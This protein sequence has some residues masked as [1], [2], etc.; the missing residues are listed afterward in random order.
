V[1]ALAAYSHSAS[2]G[3]LKPGVGAWLGLLTF[4][5]S[6]THGALRGKA[7]G[8]DE[9]GRTHK[10]QGDAEVQ[11]QVPGAELGGLRGVAAPTRGHHGLVRR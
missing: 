2:V 9:D 3:S 7:S 10:E 5:P 11:D 6:K 4:R 1:P 8:D